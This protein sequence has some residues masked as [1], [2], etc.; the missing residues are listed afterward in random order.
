[1][2]IISTDVARA[3]RILREGKVVTFA[4][5]YTMKNRPFAYLSIIYL[6]LRRRQNGEMSLVAQHG[7]VT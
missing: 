7:R 1:M 3:T 6:I 2:S 5:M 4:T